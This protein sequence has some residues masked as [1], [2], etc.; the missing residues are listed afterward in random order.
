M[1][2]SIFMSGEHASKLATIFTRSNKK[3]GLSRVSSFNNF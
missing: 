2:L 1:F 3:R